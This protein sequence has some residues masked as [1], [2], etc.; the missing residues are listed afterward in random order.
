M[1]WDVEKGKGAGMFGFQKLEVWKL[2]VNYADLI[3]RITRIFPDDERFGLTSQLRRAS[4][5]ISSNIA[6][7]SGR[8]SSRDFVR[9]IAIAYGS[10]MET[11]S[12]A[13][14][15]QRQGFLSQQRLDEIGNMAER[16]AQML[17]RLRSSLNRQ[18]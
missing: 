5:S 16:L 13:T 10:V 8:N 14:V 1:H 17:S 11:V 9:F 18:E 4:V 7:G 6:E 3:Y 2:A 12:Q 15:A